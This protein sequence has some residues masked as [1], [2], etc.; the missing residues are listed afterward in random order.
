MGNWSCS[1]ATVPLEGDRNLDICG[2]QMRKFVLDL[3][4]CIAILMK[5]PDRRGGILVP[6]MM[7]LF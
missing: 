6:A 5:D 1:F 2:R 4:V 7:C 3:F